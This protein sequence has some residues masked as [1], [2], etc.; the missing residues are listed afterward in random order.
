MSGWH[1]SDRHARLPSNWPTLATQV[2]KRDQSTCQ[3]C[4]KKLTRGTREGEVDHIEPGD[5]HH[6]TNLQLLC[7]DCHST[8]TTSEA[9]HARQHQQASRLR[10]PEQH[11]GLR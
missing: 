10:P 7:H 11:P 6:L 3:H 5:N 2:W 8:K 4:H 1:G 9:T